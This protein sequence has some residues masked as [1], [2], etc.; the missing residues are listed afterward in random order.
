MKQKNTDWS[1]YEM[2]QYCIGCRHCAYICIAY[3]GLRTEIAQADKSEVGFYVSG[4][5]G[6]SQQ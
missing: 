3:F 1:H 6:Y 5:V 4:Q 2:S